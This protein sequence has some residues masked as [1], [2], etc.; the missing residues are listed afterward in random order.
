[1]EETFMIQQFGEKYE[2][3]RREVKGLIPLVW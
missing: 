2:R 3:Y 1:V